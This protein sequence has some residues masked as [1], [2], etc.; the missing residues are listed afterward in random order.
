[1]A[2]ATTPV[3]P[4][5]QVPE[6]AVNTNLW[7]RLF[8]DGEHA[9]LCRE[10]IYVVDL[11]GRSVCFPRTPNTAQ[12]I[13]QLLNLIFSFVA[14]PSFVIPDELSE[15]FI[16]I[17]P[18]LAAITSLS[19]FKTTDAQ[20]EILREQPNNFLKILA[21]YS[22]RNKSHF[23]RHAIFQV[24]AK[25]ASLWYLRFAE[26]FHCSTA[27]PVMAENL[28]HH[29]SFVP[30]NLVALQ[31]VQDPFFGVSYVEPAI[32]WPLKQRVNQAVRA[33]L[34]QMP[35]RPF[36]PEPN[37]IAVVTG[38]WS[39]GHS[40][41][42]IIQGLLAALKPKYH[43]TFFR[44]GHHTDHDTSL[45]DECH[46]ITSQDGLP[47]PGF[48]ASGKYQAI[49]YPDIGMCD[50]SIHLANMRL[51]PVQ[52]TFTGHSVSTMGAD[53]DYY[54]SGAS[55]EIPDHPQK[56]YSERLVLLP[57]M[58]CVHKKPTYGPVAPKAVPTD[59]IVINCPWT[60]PKITRRL[61][62]A[63]NAIAE[64]SRRP[65]FFR[66][67]AGGSL[68]QFKDAVPFDVDFAE[69]VPRG[70]AEVHY[71]LP[72]PQYMAAME[73]GHFSL[74][75]F[76][77]SGCNTVSDSLYLRVPI[78][79]REGTRW[80]N[81]V[82]PRML[83]LAGLPELIAT[84]DEEYIE[85][86]LKLIH[87]DPWREGLKNRLITTDLDATIYAASDAEAFGRAFDD[88]LRNH[89]AYKAS[90]TREPIRIAAG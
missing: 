77:F 63:M 88:L 42:R 54:I 40:V 82:G 24:N 60:G 79:C 18:S 5:L 41:H 47:D 83:R 9:R 8:A 50:M 56:Y 52:M 1:M 34:G 58:G 55:V 84:S 70:L 74:D 44:L 86:A 89:D 11:V 68:G 29:F 12:E 73:Q 48:L 85:L 22:A 14:N 46:V 59:R 69:A 72:Y 61:I 25:L 4:P 31:G 19:G 13:D 17:N 57:G 64:R 36:T 3:P 6:T 81:R 90:G 26:G 45:F 43:L 7:P 20:L 35:L 49:L 65:V 51:A 16:G 78:L 80:Y 23:D 38:H 62:E 53:I 87:D 30:E 15:K 21:F 27:S 10:M 2:I 76:H 37:K 28:R 67:Y 39:P 71:H 75:P 33:R 66:I 32:E